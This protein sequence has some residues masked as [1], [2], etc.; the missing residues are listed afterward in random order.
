MIC[1]QRGVTPHTHVSAL[2]LVCWLWLLHGVVTCSPL[3]LLDDDAR[4]L[5]AQLVTVSLPQQLHRLHLHV[6]HSLPLVLVVPLV[7][8]VLPVLQY[9]THKYA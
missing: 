1:L 3:H 8:R 9:R 4:L 2:L 6:V 5:I 7:P